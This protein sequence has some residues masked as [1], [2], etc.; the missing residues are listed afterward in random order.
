M[1][2][3]S[4]NFLGIS[5]KSPI[6]IEV[7][8]Y[9]EDIVL[10]Y[11]NSGVGAF[12]LKPFIEEDFV[13]EFDSIAILTSMAESGQDL[14]KANLN[15]KTEVYLKNILSFKKLQ[16]VPVIAAIDCVSNEKWTDFV[17]LLEYVGADAIRL[18]IF[19]FPS[20]KDFRSSDYEKT[21][22]EIATKIT[23]E[24]KIP[25]FHNISPYFTNLLNVIDQ[26]FYRGIQGISLFEKPIIK[27]IDIHE[28]EFIEPHFRPNND[29]PLFINKWL[30][31]ISSLIRKL[32]LAAQASTI[33]SELTIKHMLSGANVVIAKQ[34]LETA[35]NISNVI[36]E[37][38]HWMETQ[39]FSKIEHFQNQMNL[40][41]P[42]SLISDERNAYLKSKV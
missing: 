40:H 33:D 10:S 41:D 29:H 24:V 16:N 3:L 19:S 32:D 7:D 20:D 39:G 4:C 1:V 2:D 34:Y 8:S 11:I 17:R 12:I 9:N 21:L 28:F 26:L 36:Q 30:G 37:I 5:L 31:I 38:G 25:V 35:E 22:Y 18:S 42:A 15:T 23:Y 13:N 6:I 27:D 14:L